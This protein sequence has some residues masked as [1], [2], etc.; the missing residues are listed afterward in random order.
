MNEVK[1]KKNDDQAKIEKA[2]ALEYKSI[3]SLPK[4][5]ATGSGI[6]AEKIIQ[7]A[8]ENDIPITKDEQL[9]S[10]LQQ[11]KIGSSITPE[12]FKIVAEVITFL[13]HAEQKWQEKHKFLDTVIK[14]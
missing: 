6:S 10:L 5:L 13:Y 1:I 11:S 7:V 9:V 8:K 4:I 3:D 2:I 14:N 12:S